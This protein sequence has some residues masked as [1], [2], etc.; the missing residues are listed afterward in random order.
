MIYISDI[1]YYASLFTV[2]IGNRSSVN[3]LSLIQS[4]RTNISKLNY[5]RGNFSALK[6]QFNN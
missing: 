2:P 1:I 4:Y 6:N 3:G 5:T